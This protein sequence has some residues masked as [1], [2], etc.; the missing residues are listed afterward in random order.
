MMSIHRSSPAPSPSAPSAHRAGRVEEARAEFA[1]VLDRRAREDLPYVFIGL[2]SAIT[3]P[4]DDVVLP[5]WAAQPDW[6]PEPAA[7]IAEPAHRV[8]M[9]EALEYV[10]GC[11]IASDLTDRAT[12]FRQDMPG[13]GTDWLHSTNAPGFTPLGPWIPT[14][15]RCSA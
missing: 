14:A 12:V 10:A 13:I 5:S 7:V 15:R 8:S 4:Y 9:E 2:P 11:T 1:E 6:E 3:G